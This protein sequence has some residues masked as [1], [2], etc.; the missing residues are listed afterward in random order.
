MSKKKRII[1]VVDTHSKQEREDLVNFITSHNHLLVSVVSEKDGFQQIYVRE[2]D[3]WMAMTINNPEISIK[4]P[5]HYSS[6]EE[7]K[8]DIG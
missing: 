5:V 1:C 2:D 3:V 8:E 4:T 6:L 7:F